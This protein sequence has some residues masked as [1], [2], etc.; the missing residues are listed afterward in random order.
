MVEGLGQ[1]ARFTLTPG[2]AGDI[3][4]APQLLQDVECRIMVAD[5]AFD[6]QYLRE[7]LAQRDVCTV[8]PSHP[9][10]KVAYPLDSE[11]YRHRNLIERLFCRIK[12]FRR[13]ATRYDKLAARFA[14]FVAI[15]ACVAWLA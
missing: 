15:A 2:Q 13:V 7:A 5:T 11:L 3:T 8:I 12:H 14:S 9:K 4:Q 10:R 1:L 6:A